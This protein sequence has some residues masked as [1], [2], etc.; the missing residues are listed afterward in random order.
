MLLWLIGCSPSPADSADLSFD[1]PFTGS[2]AAMDTATGTDETEAGDTSTDSRWELFAVV[3]SWSLEVVDGQP[4]P[5]SSHNA[6]YIS[7]ATALWDGDVTAVTGHCTARRS[8]NGVPLGSHLKEAELGSLHSEVGTDIVS[9]GDCGRLRTPGWEG[10][11]TAYMSNQLINDGNWF[12]GMG[13]GSE[14]FTEKL[15]G[16]AAYAMGGYTQ[17][18]EE[19]VLTNAV[20]VLDPDSGE[21]TKIG[22]LST[23]PDGILYAPPWYAIWEP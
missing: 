14:I 22:D 2:S 19:V 5:A 13:D 1:W 7:A 15:S 3:L 4:V 23:L 6:F 21:A 16:Y 12:F 11:P 9:L 10:L 20:F 18:G 8:L 17:L